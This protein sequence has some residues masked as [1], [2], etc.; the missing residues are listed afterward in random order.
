MIDKP[1]PEELIIFETLRN[2]VACAE[3]L[4]DDFDNLSSFSEKDYGNV[5]LYQYPFL[6]FDPQYLDDEKLSKKENFQKMFKK[7]GYKL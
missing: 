7:F 5:R 4:F 3:I 6:S 1:T 2:P